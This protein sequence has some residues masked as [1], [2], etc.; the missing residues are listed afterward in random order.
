M[1]A[2]DYSKWPTPAA[3]DRRLQAIGL[4]LRQPTRIPELLDEV[5]DEVGTRTLRQFVADASDTSR[6][7]N[8]TG[9]AELEVDEM[10]ALTSVTVIGYNS[11]PGYGLGDVQLIQEAGKPQTRLV[12]GRGSL[13]AW[14]TEAVL[15]PVPLIFP[16]GRQNIEVTGKFGYGPI[17][18]PSLWSAVAGE[19]AYRAG[20]EGLFSVSGRVTE[21]MEGDV[22]RKV[23]LGK[24]ESLPW[25]GTYEDRVKYFTR[26]AGRR[27]RNLRNRMV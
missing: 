8:G 12:V 2:N 14:T 9:T 11:L 22:R 21:K 20:Q 7:Y 23:E 17:I 24:A 10:V 25:H 5:I 6:I 18:P 16:A 1:S 3:I 19:V 27:F 13:A 26:P 15:T 4:T